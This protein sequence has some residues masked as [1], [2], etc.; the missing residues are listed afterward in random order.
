[1]YKLKKRIKINIY[2]SQIK[3]QKVKLINQRFFLIGLRNVKYK[4]LQTS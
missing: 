2:I 1:M 3:N 4:K